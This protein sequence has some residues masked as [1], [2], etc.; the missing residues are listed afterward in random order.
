M[1]LSRS[2]PKFTYEEN[3]GE[4]TIYIRKSFVLYILQKIVK[5]NFQIEY[6]ICHQQKVLKGS[7]ILILVR[8]NTVLTKFQLTEELY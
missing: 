4:S 5:I 7:T 1:F 8:F 3:K 6:C 2:K